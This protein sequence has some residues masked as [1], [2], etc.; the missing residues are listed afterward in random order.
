[1]TLGRITQ[2]NDITG[3]GTIKA[4]D[5]ATYALRVHF[6]P[7]ELRADALGA[8]IVFEPVTDHPW[9]HSRVSKLAGAIDVRPA[10]FGDKFTARM[11]G[12]HVPPA[13]P[14]VWENPVK[15]RRTR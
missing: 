4:T 7:R 3:R 11:R 8:V 6:L 2:W 5:G 1:M 9:Y 12:E 15:A 14:F 10:S 13:A